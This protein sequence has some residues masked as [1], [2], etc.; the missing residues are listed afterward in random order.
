M[1]LFNFETAEE[2]RIREEMEREEQLSVFNEQVKNLEA[3][4]GEYAEMAARA[5]INGDAATY[6][7]ACNG[8]IELHEVISNL[9]QTKINFDIINISNSVATTMA[10]AMRAL[11]A[12]ASN[13][14][15]SIDIRQIQKTQ[16]K[17]AKYMR[18]IKIKNKAMI[19]AMGH[20]NPANKTRSSE[21][22]AAIRPMIDAARSKMT[23]VSTPATAGINIAAEIEAE[24]N[25][26]I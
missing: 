10:T 12:M 2:K 23:N 4:L 22:L 18:G 14:A 11:D 5:E 3:K 26:T 13:K 20:S 24:K 15:N 7:A 16:V 9:N 21:E 19:S 1:G 6:D 17:V 25:K 8:L